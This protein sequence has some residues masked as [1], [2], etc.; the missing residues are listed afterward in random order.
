MRTTVPAPPPETAEVDGY[1]TDPAV[2][3]AYL[4]LAAA[5]IKSF[6][7]VER[8]WWKVID[9]TT[10]FPL[11]IA[12]FRDGSP[13]CTVG[14]IAV[15]LGYRT[16]RQVFTVV[17]GLPD[18]PTDE[19]PRDPHPVVAALM[20]ELNCRDLWDLFAWSDSARDDQIVDRLREVA[21]ELRGRAA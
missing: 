2:Q 1:F 7:K 17:C 10:G 19:A 8:E 9:P 12:D 13:T 20:R 21:T 15:Q 5:H 11:L 16:H 6:G 18:E 14:A 4:E 3:A